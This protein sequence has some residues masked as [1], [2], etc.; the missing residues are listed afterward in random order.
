MTRHYFRP[1]KDETVISTLH[2]LRSVIVRE[3]QD[4]LEHVD[5]LLRL[6]GV[7]PD[8]L[9]MPAKR[10]KHFA[11]GKLRIAV[12]EALRDG[13]MTGADIARR[14]QGN[15]LDYALAYK[16]VYQCL[17]HMQGAGLVRSDGGKW[18]LAS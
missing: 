13:P 3:G 16:R 2:Y 6:R 7:D 18:R 8:S 11:R 17:N 4:G 14:V 12:M 1:I 10:P 9:P 15:G 5:A